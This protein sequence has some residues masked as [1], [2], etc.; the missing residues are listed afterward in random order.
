M[1]IKANSF[2]KENQ[3]QTRLSKC[4]SPSDENAKKVKV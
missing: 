4:L 2:G 3:K 1:L